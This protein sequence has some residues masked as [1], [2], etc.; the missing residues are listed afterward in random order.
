MLKLQYFGHLMWRATHWKRPWCWERLKA[1]GE[2]GNGRWDGWVASLIQ[3]TW[4]WANSGRWWGTEKP[5]LLQSIGPQRVG[6]DLATEQQQPLSEPMYFWFPHK[7]CIEQP[8]CAKHLLWHQRHKIEC[9]DQF[10]IEEKLQRLK[11]MQDA[12]RVLLSA[13]VGNH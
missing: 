7:K 6:C 5:D 4:T 9:V 1:E 2:E 8:P 12:V 10:D 3:W 13:H 11:Q